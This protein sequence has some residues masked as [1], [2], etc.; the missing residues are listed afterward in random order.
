MEILHMNTKLLL[1]MVLMAT[2]TAGCATGQKIRP[3]TT[4]Q[5]D[6]LKMQLGTIG[7]TGAQ[8]LPMTK[9]QTPAKGSGKGAAGGAASGAAIPIKILKGTGS[10]I[11]HCAAI[12]ILT[13]PFIPVGAVIGSIGGAITANSA[14][15][16]NAREA[17]LKKALASLKMQQG[18]RD[19]VLTTATELATFPIE[20][21][22]N[23]GPALTD[24]N[25]DY[26]PLKAEG[27]DTV[28]EVTIN[29][30]TLT[31][32]GRVQPSLAI[33]FYSSARLI[34]TADNNVMFSREYE[35]G[36]KQ[37][38]F[39]TWAADNAKKFNEEIN[40]CYDN[41]SGQMVRD[42]YVNNTLLKRI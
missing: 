23:H 40:R 12:S 16:V 41:L 11:P 19:R 4:Q 20:L 14:E 15:D 24:L 30:L 22:A 31:G 32:S 6:V 42:I 9:I 10:C 25:S 35:C 7:V 2:L 13:I 33:R 18:L 38:K 29:R 26:R 39:E 37:H 3:M 28:H 17:A 34:S 27:I 5:T 1:G 21:A 8:Y 36:S